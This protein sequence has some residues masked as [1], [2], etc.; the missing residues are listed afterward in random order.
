M[1]QCVQCV[2]C[3]ILFVYKHRIWI[4]VYIMIFHKAIVWFNLNDQDCVW[5]NL[6][7]RDCVW[8]NVYNKNHLWINLYFTILFIKLLIDSVCTIKTAFD[9]FGIVWESFLAHIHINYNILHYFLSISYQTKVE[10]KLNYCEIINFHGVTFL[11]W[12]FSFS[13]PRNLN[14]NKYNFTVTCRYVC[15]ILCTKH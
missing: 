13:W 4:N 2:M 8:F 5:I 15:I 10:W 3:L 6:N 14:A 11:R 1:T 7:D 9:S 12:N